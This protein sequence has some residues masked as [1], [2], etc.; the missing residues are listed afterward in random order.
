MNV[1]ITNNYI[2]GL[3]S[4]DP[5]KLSCFVSSLSHIPKNT[6]YQT[7]LKDECNSLA[8]GMKSQMRHSRNGVTYSEYPFAM[9]LLTKQN[10][11]I[12]EP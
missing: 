1:R 5:T 11:E 7:T 10:N 9:L 4:L 8:G 2:H 12:L 3:I 6:C